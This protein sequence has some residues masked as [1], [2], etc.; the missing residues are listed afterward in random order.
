MGL[1][2]AEMFQDKPESVIAQ[3]TISAHYPSGASD[4]AKIVTSTGRAAEVRTATSAVDGVARVEDGGDHTPDG[5]LTTISVVLEDTP[6]SQATKDTT[7][8]FTRVSGRSAH[9]QADQA[10][11]GT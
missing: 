1:P 2:Q 11:R 4:P 3:E 7:G 10:V 5:E 9:H 6:D 8:S